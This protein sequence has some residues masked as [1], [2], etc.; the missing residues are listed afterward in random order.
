[1]IHLAAVSK[2]LPDSPLAVTEPP[3]EA[4]LLTDYG[5][6]AAVEGEPFVGVLTPDAERTSA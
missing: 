3:L 2:R 1:M 4:M 6:V 5:W